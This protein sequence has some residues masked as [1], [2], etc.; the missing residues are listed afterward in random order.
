MSAEEHSTPCN[1]FGVKKRDNGHYPDANMAHKCSLSKIFNAQGA[2]CA[3]QATPGCRECDYYNQG[4]ASHKNAH[5][6]NDYRLK[7]R[8]TPNGRVQLRDVLLMVVPRTGSDSPETGASEEIEEACAD[9]STS[10]ASEELQEVGGDYPAAGVSMEVQ[11]V[12]YDS[13]NKLC[14]FFG[15]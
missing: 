7:K 15:I 8:R 13:G 10:G 4:K 12:D 3:S 2:Q 1:A 5:R 9:S 11:E 14:H 6:A